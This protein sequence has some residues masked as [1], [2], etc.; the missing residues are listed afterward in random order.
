MGGRWQS[1]LKK[2][3]AGVNF[4][5]GFFSGGDSP[6]TKIGRIG[7]ALAAKF[8]REKSYKIL[9]RNWCFGKGEIDII[10]RDRQADVVVFVEVKLRNSRALVPGYF[11]VGKKKR[12]VLRKTCKAYLEK[13]AMSRVSYRFDVIAIQFDRAGDVPLIQHY[14]N[15]ELF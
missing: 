8:L 15:V 12:D 1:V 7:E 2:I 14:E 3:A 13:F 9:S 10:A 6:S 5:S 4:L 11:S